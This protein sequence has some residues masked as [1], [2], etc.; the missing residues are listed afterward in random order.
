MKRGNH[1]NK[2]LGEQIDEL[3]KE[4]RK[5]ESKKEAL[6]PTYFKTEFHDKFFTDFEAVFPKL[7]EK[8]KHIDFEV[9][10]IYDDE[11]G[12]D[13]TITRGTLIDTNDE[14]F[15]IEEELQIG[16]ETVGDYKRDEIYEWVQQYLYNRDIDVISDY[17]DR[18]TNPNI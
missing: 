8:I 15:E 5:I 1:M 10:S 2:T 18:L 16:N 13:L 9:H 12:Y 11:G 6:Y 14:A 7:K 4:Q 17:I 3:N